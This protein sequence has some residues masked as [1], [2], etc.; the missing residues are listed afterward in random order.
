MYLERGRVGG[1]VGYNGQLGIVKSPLDWL[2]Q[3]QAVAEIIDVIQAD[4]VTKP[5]FMR[6]S[7]QQQIGCLGSRDPGT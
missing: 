1:C 7:Q 6:V 5:A 3:E 2:E 4:L